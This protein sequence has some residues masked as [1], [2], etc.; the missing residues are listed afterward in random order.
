MKEIIQVT[1]L[2]NIIAPPYGGAIVNK[3]GF[4]QIV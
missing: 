3:N 2:D 1:P 4:S